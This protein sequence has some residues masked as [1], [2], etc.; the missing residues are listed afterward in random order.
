MHLASLLSLSLS[1]SL[2]AEESQHLSGAGT[3]KA[4]DQLSFTN[5]QRWDSPFLKL[6]QQ[7]PLLLPKNWQQS[8]TLPQPPANSSPRTRAELALLKTLISQR[9]KFETKIRAEVI[10][11]NFTF[12]KHRYL[13]LT[14]S[15]KRPATAKLLKA[16]FNDSGIAIFT[17]KKHFN[18]VRPSLLAEK[19][20]TPIGTSLPI[21]KHPAYPSGHASSA[22]S[23]AYLLSELDPE[24]A[25]T[26]RQSATA[27]TEHREIAGLHYPSDSEAGRL[28]ARQL[29][30]IL[31]ANPHCQR[32][33]EQAKK[34]W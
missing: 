18:R 27:I 10:L 26:Y 4:L 13:D 20:A 19:L 28:L 23:I 31:L 12:G 25:E 21:P 2:A 16:A 9:Q 34:E 30:D 11:D 3:N 22:W 33:L 17:F 7:S 14:D 6:A 5:T 1:L 32:Q 8:I 24:N 29:I 15:N